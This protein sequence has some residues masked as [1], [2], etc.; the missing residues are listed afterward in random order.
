MSHNAQKVAKNQQNGK[1][2]FA[3]GFLPTI[4]IFCNKFFRG[5]PLFSQSDRSST[6][7]SK[8]GGAAPPPRTF[9]STKCSG[10]ISALHYQWQTSLLHPKQKR[11]IR[12]SSPTAPNTVPP[13]RPPL[14]FHCPSLSLPTDAYFAEG[15]YDEVAG[16]EDGSVK[17]V[18]QVN[19]PTSAVAMLCL[20]LPFHSPS[21]L[22][23]SAYSLTSA[24][25]CTPAPASITRTHA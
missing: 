5:R 15:E 19:L 11:V 6:A 25:T 8:N 18:R 9:Q 16:Q 23:V 22:R 3:T 1:S 21:R 10:L 14:P 2:T 20:R 24:A 12:S 7:K 4:Y 13:P 17:R